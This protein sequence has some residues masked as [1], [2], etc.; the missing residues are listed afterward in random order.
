MS[1]MISIC[2]IFFLAFRIRHFDMDMYILVLGGAYDYDPMYMFALLYQHRL[3]NGD[4][5]SEYIILI[6]SE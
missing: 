2:R 6:V 5:I 4:F 1:F 3:R